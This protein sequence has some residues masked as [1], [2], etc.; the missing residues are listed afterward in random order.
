MRSDPLVCRVREIKM[1]EEPHLRPSEI[2]QKKV[3]ISLKV[4]LAALPLL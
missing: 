2:L 3:M 1:R 4:K